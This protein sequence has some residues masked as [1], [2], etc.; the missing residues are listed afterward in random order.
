MLLLFVLGSVVEEI[1]ISV[2]F[3]EW[4]AKIKDLITPSIDY[5][6]EIEFYVSV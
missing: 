3:L 4:S 1:G 6:N 2:A 5:S